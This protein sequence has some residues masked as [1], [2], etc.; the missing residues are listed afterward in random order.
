MN[1]PGVSVRLAGSP[2][3]ALL[4]F[5]LY[6][7]VVLG[8]YQDDVAWWLALG[9]VAAAFRT[10]G[11]VGKLRRYNAWL[12][13]WQAMGAE[14]EAPPRRKKRRGLMVAAGA[15]FLT[16]AIPLSM[17]PGTKPSDGLT[18]LWCVACLT[19]LYSLAW[20]LRRAV[21]RSSS[22]AAAKRREEAEAAPVAWLL[23]CASSSPSRAE[24]QGNLPEYCARLIGRG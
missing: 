19:L 8:W 16:V 21:K 20:M 17:S 9:A 24:A 11:A 12:A 18:A 3:G 14:S 6:A 15:A 2:L 4:L 5:M 22:R 10:L 1:R 13:Q 7:A 23:P